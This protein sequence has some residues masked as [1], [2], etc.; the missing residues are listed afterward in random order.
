M[1]DRGMLATALQPVAVAVTEIGR[2]AAGAPEIQW[3]HRGKP[4]ELTLQG[5]H[6]ASGLVPKGMATK[7]WS[8]MTGLAEG[9]AR[10]GAGWLVQS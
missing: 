6:P 9:F 1:K 3:L 7:A 8:F 4:R 2:I 5:S 10:D